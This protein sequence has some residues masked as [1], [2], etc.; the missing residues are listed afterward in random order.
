[1]SWSKTVLLLKFPG[2]NNARVSPTASNT[3]NT[4]SRIS[5]VGEDLLGAGVG[6]SSDGIVVA[7]RSCLGGKGVG[8][9][10]MFGADTLVEST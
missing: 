10:C 5:E 9:S 3:M 4:I 1:M 7:G 8:W 2:R 6:V